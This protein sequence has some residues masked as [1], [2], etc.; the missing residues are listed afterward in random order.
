M[1]AYSSSPGLYQHKRAHHPEL[2]NRRTHGSWSDV[3]LDGAPEAEGVAEDE[4]ALDGAGAELGEEALD[5]ADQLLR[6]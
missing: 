4:E 3:A 2:I 6:D 5:R 1:K